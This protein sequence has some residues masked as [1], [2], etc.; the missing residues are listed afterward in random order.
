MIRLF[1]ENGISPKGIN[2]FYLNLLFYEL[3]NLFKFYNILVGLEN[4]F[5]YGTITSI[6]QITIGIFFVIFKESSPL[7][8]IKFSN[9]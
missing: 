4:A 3:L 6:F 7:S 5:S 8:I 9:Y 2:I 1:A